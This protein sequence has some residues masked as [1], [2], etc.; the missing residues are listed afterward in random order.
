MYFTFLMGVVVACSMQLAFLYFQD[1]PLVTPIVTNGDTHNLT[2][3]NVTN[4]SGHDLT[5]PNATNRDMHYLAHP[6]ATNR[7]MHDLAHP[8]VTNEENHTDG[9]NTA[10]PNTNGTQPPTDPVSPGQ[11]LSILVVRAATMVL[12]ETLPLYCNTA[13]RLYNMYQDYAI[14][15]MV[16]SFMVTEFMPYRSLN[17]LADALVHFVGLHA[18]LLLYQRA[19]AGSIRG[20]AQA[21]GRIA[22]VYHNSHMSS[23]LFTN[24]FI[25]QCLWILPMPPCDSERWS[26]VPHG[27]EACRIMPFVARFGFAQCMTYAIKALKGPVLPRLYSEETEILLHGLAPI[28]TMLTLSYTV[29]N[30]GSMLHSDS[31]AALGLST[32][33]FTAIH[34]ANTTQQRGLNAVEC[35]HR[36]VRSMYTA[37][38]RLLDIIQQDLTVN[39]DNSQE[40]K[41]IYYELAS[42]VLWTT[43]VVACILHKGNK[44]INMGNKH[45]HIDAETLHSVFMCCLTASIL[46]II[47]YKWLLEL[48]SPPTWSKNTLF[49]EAW[50]LAKLVLFTVLNTIVLSVTL[51]GLHN[52][53]INLV[54]PL[55]LLGLY[56]IV[57][58]TCFPPMQ[59]PAPVEKRGQAGPSK[60]GKRGSMFIV[61]SMWYTQVCLFLVAATFTLVVMTNC[62]PQGRTLIKLCT[63]FLAPNLTEAVN[64][65][66]LDFA[67]CLKDPRFPECKNAIKRGICLQRA[68]PIA[69]FASLF[70]EQLGTSIPNY[71][72][73]TSEDMHSIFKHTDDTDDRKRFKRETKEAIYLYWDCLNNFFPQLC[74]RCLHFTHRCW[75]AVQ[76]LNLSVLT[77]LSMED[78]ITFERI[79][80]VVVFVYSLLADTW[81]GI[82]IILD[83]LSKEV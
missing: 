50:K 25:A 29:L 1:I 62:T 72:F 55:V 23:N 79:V 71:C 31:W 54:Y 16:A 30:T 80:D 11:S 81:T 75:D 76:T 35:M 7:D 34:A 82:H 70:H 2:H 5:R 78:L 26:L 3:P 52:C 61:S 73:M 22:H 12:L 74:D 49:I 28:L 56:R 60:T 68:K 63:G 27:Y 40:P 48:T 18:A 43:M 37:L 51:L 8:N 53:G 24:L 4:G 32:V 58:E 21:K 64:F 38:A 57:N 77:E 17:P 67:S 15:N 59:Q 47:L 6:N 19:S 13:F 10:H 66:G 39:Q 9:P 33:I 41:V 83:T 20:E 69:W 36:L 44:N 65:Y 46:F 42:P 45:I 14:V